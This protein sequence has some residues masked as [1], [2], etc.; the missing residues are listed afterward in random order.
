MRANPSSPATPSR[1]QIHPPVAFN[2]ISKPKKRTS[3]KVVGVVLLSATGITVIVVV[4]VLVYMMSIFSS[5]GNSCN[6]K[7]T[8][9]Y[10]TAGQA[11][12]A[13]NDVAIVPGVTGSTAHEQKQDGDCVDSL[14]TV[15][16]QRSFTVNETAQQAVNQVNA[17]MENEGY[18]SPTYDHNTDPNGNPC[19]ANQG[20]DFGLTYSKPGQ[21]NI[22][23]TMNCAA[24]YDSINDWQQLPV[25]EVDAEIMFAASA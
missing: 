11:I 16:L 12:P 25:T 2:P 23:V 19:S 1:D 4:A 15:W 5:I 8:N 6:T 22:T 14:P 21:P 3:F 10:N 18:K 7:R 20:G 9:T 13:F 17:T 24:G